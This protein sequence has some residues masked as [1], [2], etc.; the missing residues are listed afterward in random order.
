[1]NSK[2]VA[3]QCGRTGVGP[4]GSLMIYNIFFLSMFNND[5]FQGFTSAV[6][7]TDTNT[8]KCNLSVI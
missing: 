7:N 4:K 2:T 3:G 8:I 6:W 5:Y 1:M